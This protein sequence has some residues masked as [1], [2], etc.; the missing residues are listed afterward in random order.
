MGGG[1]KY[2]RF[3]TQSSEPFDPLELM[4]ATEG[5]V[6]RPGPEGLERKYTAFYATGVYGG[7]ATGYAVG[8]SLRCFFCWS[9]LSRDFPEVRGAFYSPAK[10]Y[11]RLDEAA[12]RYKV[13]KLRLSGAEPLLGVEHTLALLEYVEESDYPL[14][15]L[16][17]NG[18][19]LG[20]DKEL[21]KKLAKFS[22]VHVRVSLKAASPEG[23]ERR[24][25]AKGGFY[26]LPFKAIEH[27]LD[28]GVS[29]HVAAMSDPR[30]MPKAERRALIERLRSIDPR[31]AANLEE[32][33]CDPYDTT[34]IRMA[35]YGIDPIEFFSKG[36]R[37]GEG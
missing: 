24:T 28:A 26:E 15:I 34:L 12:R 27:L 19:A 9:E 33:V 11:R 13:R 37:G 30:I 23:F 3:L 18:I 6:C 5:I 8:C 21:A 35:A 36:G 17:T 1:P 14:F 4:R 29:F 16:E 31:V 22:K 20:A 32:E 10:A 7:I 25:G 2:P